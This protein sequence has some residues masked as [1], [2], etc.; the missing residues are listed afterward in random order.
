MNDT[1]DIYSKFLSDTLLMGAHMTFGQT[2]KVVKD[3]RTLAIKE[4]KWTLAVRGAYEAYAS[5]KNYDAALRLIHGTLKQMHDEETQ[6]V[7][8]TNCANA[9]P[10]IAQSIYHALKSN[11]TTIKDNDTRKW[12]DITELDVD[13]HNDN[14]IRTNLLQVEET[15]SANGLLER[16]QVMKTALASEQGNAGLEL[17]VLY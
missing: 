5:T 1:L 15:Y 8:S 9:L 10:P 13:I 6:A 2:A 7:A 3:F 12:R 17:T 14:R 4:P 16:R 11:K